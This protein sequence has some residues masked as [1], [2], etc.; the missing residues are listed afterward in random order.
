MPSQTSAYA[1]CGARIKRDR[2]Y[3]IATCPKC[4]ELIKKRISGG[5]QQKKIRRYCDRL[6]VDF[7]LLIY[8]RTQV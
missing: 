3:L 1:A 5:Q 8:E 4:R 6:L 2:S 7:C